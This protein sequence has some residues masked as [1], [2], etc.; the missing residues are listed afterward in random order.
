MAEENGLVPELVPPKS[1]LVRIWRWSVT[2]KTARLIRIGAALPSLALAGWLLQNFL[3]L[4]GVVDLLA[5]RIDLAFF[6]LALSIAG[7]A[8]TLGVRRQKV[9]WVMVASTSFVVVLGLDWWAPKPNPRQVTDPYSITP[10]VNSGMV[11]SLSMAHDCG[12]WVFHDSGPE[13]TMLAQ[14]LDA[15]FVAVRWKKILP[16][17]IL[18]G[19]P[20]VKGIEI[21]A[22]DRSDQCFMALQGAFIAMGQRIRFRAN[23]TLAPKTLQLTILKP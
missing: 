7:C 14:N 8:A 20:S 9:A 22:R 16:D 4:R 11:V 3:Q 19:Q 23:S 2:Q 12:I 13:S 1:G 17:A 18:Y 15:M 5:S 6:G 10:D 21:A